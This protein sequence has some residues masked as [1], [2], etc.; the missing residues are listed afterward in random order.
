MLMAN[1]TN[2]SNFI[3]GTRKLYHGKIADSRGGIKVMGVLDD[4]H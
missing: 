1:Y 3:L 4:R 2:L